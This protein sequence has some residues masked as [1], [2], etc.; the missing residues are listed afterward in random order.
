MAANEPR[1]RD[2][3]KVA[4]I[5][6]DAGGEVVGRTRLQKIAYLLELAGLGEGFDFE[7][8]HYGPYSD[9][10]AA[11]TRLAGAFGLI[12]EEE[13]PTAWGGFYSVYTA[14]APANDPNRQRV[15]FVR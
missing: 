12:K 3:Q 11:A 14:T 13:R 8:R 4:D 6:H 2:F 7:Y 10:L 5:V 9:Q 1:K 15:E